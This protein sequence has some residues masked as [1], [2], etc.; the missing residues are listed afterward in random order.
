MKNDIININVETL[1]PQRR[2]FIFI[3]K[4]VE[5]TQDFA[6]TVFNIKPDNILV[7]DNVLSEAGLMENIA[8][9]CAARIGYLNRKGGKG[10]SIG[11]IGSVKN[12]EIKMLP[13]ANQTIETHIK[14]LNVFASITMV[15]AIV[16]LNDE[17]IATG[18]MKVSEQ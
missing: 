10:V 12:F 8:Q 1:L 17:I 7:I 5:C 6:K 4:L 2:P 18:E 9:T 13:A 14:V 15:E 3:D 11:V 16:K